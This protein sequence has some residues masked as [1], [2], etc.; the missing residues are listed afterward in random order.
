MKKWL[1]ILFFALPLG[2][3]EVELIDETAIVKALNFILLDHEWTVGMEFELDK[4]IE[5]K[6]LRFNFD[7]YDAFDDLI[8]EGALRTDQITGMATY[9]SFDLHKAI[10]M[11]FISVRVY[12]LKIARG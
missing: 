7:V 5:G 11:G 1:L 8:F 3:S 10:Q 6:L 9:R 4:S 2:S 12:D